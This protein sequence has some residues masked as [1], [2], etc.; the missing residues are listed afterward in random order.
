MRLSAYLRILLSTW[1]RSDD[2]DEVEE[3]D[4]LAEEVDAAAVGVEG[5]LGAEPEVGVEPAAVG[6][7]AG[8]P[9]PGTRG[10]GLVVPNPG[11]KLA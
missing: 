4:G 9:N 2:P 1:E 8:G 11:T 3:L 6:L 10:V 7:T 5:P